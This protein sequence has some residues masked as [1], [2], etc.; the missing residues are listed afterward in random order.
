M[1]YIA[2]NLRKNLELD[3]FPEKVGELQYCI[4]I[5]INRFLWEKKQDY[6][7]MNDVIGALSG[8][9]MEFYRRVV[10]PFEDQKRHDN[11]DV[12]FD[13]GV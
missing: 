7:D 1:P 13:R 10:A 2:E 12:Y 8:A 9:Q 6:Q 4:A 11:G 5:L 3:M